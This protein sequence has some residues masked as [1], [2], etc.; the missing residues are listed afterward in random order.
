M[1]TSLPFWYSAGYQLSSRPSPRPRPRVPRAGGSERDPEERGETDRPEEPESLRGAD[2]TSVLVLG[3][4]GAGRWGA[5]LT[6]GREEVGRGG[7]ERVSGREEVGRSGADRTSE[8]VGR[9]GAGR[10]C[11]R[12]DAGRSGADRGSYRGR[13]VVSRLAPPRSGVT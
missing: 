2:R 9:S 3:R 5:D 11:G 7:A 13:A 1:G 10:A 8:E 12:T 4:S 6:S